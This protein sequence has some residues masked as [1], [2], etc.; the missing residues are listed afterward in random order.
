MSGLEATTGSA[1]P[2][3]SFGR[4]VSEVNR[5]GELVERPRTG[6]GPPSATRSG[7]AAVRRDRASTGGT[8]TVDSCTRVGALAAARRAV[9]TGVE[10]DGYPILAHGRRPPGSSARASASS[11]SRY[12]TVRRVRSVF[13]PRCWTPGST[14]PRADP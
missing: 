8:L 9:R 5:A 4:A 12:G 13:S 14:P 7:L 6:F 1:A 11:P 10:L 2:P 3:L